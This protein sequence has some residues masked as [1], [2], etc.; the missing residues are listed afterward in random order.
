MTKRGQGEGSIYKRPSGR[1]R[2]LV[3]DAEGKRISFSARTRAEVVEWVERTTSQVDDGLTYQGAKTTIRDYLILWLASMEKMASNNGYPRITTYKHYNGIAQNY[4]IPSLGALVLKDLTA[5]QLEHFYNKWIA[6]GA[7]IPTVIKAHKILHKVL[8]QAADTGLIHRNIA[9]LVKPPTAPYR[10]MQVWSEQQVNLFLTAA[11]EDRYYSLFYLALATGARQMELLALQWSD[12]DWSSRILHVCRQLSRFG[13]VF[14]KPKTSTGIRSIELGPGT[15]DILKDH[16]EKQHFEQK[17][18]KNIWQ[19]RDLIFTNKRGGTVDYRSLVIHHF[20]P[21]AAAAGLPAIRFHDMRHTAATLML[22]H[23]IPPVIVA[24]RLGH[25]LDVLMKTY[26][27]FI[28]SMQGEA[29]RLMDDLITP[30]S[31]NIGKR[32]K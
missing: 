17:F 3:Q 27:H 13:G 30:I 16:Y 25:K 1:W 31:I 23:G 24:G 18:F 2:G 22:S 29:A 14:V 6:E 19:D 8:K 5:A 28:P 10:E 12:L 15:I 9:D 7:G 21:I 26:A 11:I 32:E 4:L 20:K